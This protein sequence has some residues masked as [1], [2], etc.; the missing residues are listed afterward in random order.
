[1]NKR[2]KILS[3]MFALAMGL[4][5]AM[6]MRAS[7]DASPAIPATTKCRAQML[8]SSWRT[9]LNGAVPGRSSWRR[10]MVSSRASQ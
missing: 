2:T 7:A 3:G 6:P 9:T 10:S 1:M 5:V 4:S 8:G